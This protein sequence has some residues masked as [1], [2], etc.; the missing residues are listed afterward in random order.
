MM[1]RDQ[2]FFLALSVLSGGILLLS[3]IFFFVINQRESDD[4]RI[5][6]P[7][8]KETLRNIQNVDWSSVS[9][10]Y[11]TSSG[12]DLL[13]SI[14]IARVLK[15]SGKTIHILDECSSSC[16]NILIIEKNVVIEPDTIVALHH[17]A[18]SL[19]AISQRVLPEISRRY[20]EIAEIE[21]SW[22]AENGVNPELSLIPQA[23]IETRCLVGP[24]LDDQLNYDM[25]EYNA[26]VIAWIPPLDI[27]EMFGISAHGDWITDENEF[28]SKILSLYS[29]SPPPP[30]VTGGAVET[31]E[32]GIMYDEMAL[33]RC[34]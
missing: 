10:I 3:I 12:G 18:Q 15:N 26:R 30:I 8:D 24:A 23:M 34:A 1:K 13:E 31:K 6:G 9:E 14:E 17:T 19:A 27:K 22:Y 33:D 28:R 7:L 29:G 21:R 25:L 16:I 11:V 20:S 32:Y 2:I 5:S 4:L